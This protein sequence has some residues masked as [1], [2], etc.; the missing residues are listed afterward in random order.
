[1]TLRAAADDLVQVPI[2]SYLE[3]G[4]NLETGLVDGDFTK[5]LFQG[6][7]LRN[8]ISVTV[9]EV[10][11]SPGYYVVEFTPDV[12]GLWTWYVETPA[13]CV[14]TE[15]VQV[16]PI[17]SENDQIQRLLEIW[18]ILG[19][20]PDSPMCVSKARQE[21]GGIVLEQTEIGKKVVVQRVP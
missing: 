3:D 13:Q 2:P 7:T 8:D 10:G 14:L 21:A 5:T 12:D 1:M 6:D 18:R 9:T 19:L 20:D 16:G 4:I 11:A 17:G 15:Q